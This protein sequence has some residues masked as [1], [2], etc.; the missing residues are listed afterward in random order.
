MCVSLHPS[1]CMCPHSWVLACNWFMFFN[2]AL[3]MVSRWQLWMNFSSWRADLCVCATLWCQQWCEWENSFPP[4]SLSFLVW[5][6]MQLIL[7]Y[8]AGSMLCCCSKLVSF[9]ASWVREFLLTT[10]V[11]QQL[12]KL[13]FLSLVEI[14]IWFILTNGGL[15]FC[16]I[17][18]NFTL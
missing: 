3:C 18:F 4:W 17:T 14:S 11:N 16:P 9:L 1:K 12:S 13:N 15:S 7:T 5:H 2:S 6:V 8:T 10:L